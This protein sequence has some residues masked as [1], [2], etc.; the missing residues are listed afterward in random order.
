MMLQY[1]VAESEQRA[2]AM[3]QQPAYANRIVVI[4][5]EASYV[6]TVPPLQQ[7]AQTIWAHIIV[8]G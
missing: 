2:L 5:R 6:I 3:L 1:P 4:D 7:A 8:G